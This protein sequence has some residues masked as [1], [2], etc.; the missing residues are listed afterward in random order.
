M[1]QIIKILKR[2]AIINPYY[3]M[4]RDLKKSKNLNLFYEN[5]K[6]FKN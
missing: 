4:N 6:K 1:K 2:N 5:K 3:L